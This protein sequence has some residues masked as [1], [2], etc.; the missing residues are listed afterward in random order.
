MPGEGRCEQA[1]DGHVVALAL[2]RERASMPGQVRDLV[3]GLERHGAERAFERAMVLAAAALEARNEISFLPRHGRALAHR[4]RKYRL[5]I[6]RLFATT[7][8]QPWI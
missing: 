1:R 4:H 6:P 5:R 8:P 7:A 3:A 2:L